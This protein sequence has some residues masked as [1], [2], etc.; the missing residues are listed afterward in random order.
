[1]EP[2]RKAAA[3][4]PPKQKPLE[5]VSKRRDEILQVAAELFAA[6]GYEETTIRE[7]GDAAGILSGSLYHHFQTK[8][9]MLHE[10]L[11]GFIAMIPEYQ[12]IVDQGRPPK[13]TMCAMIDLALRTSVSNPHTV[14]ITVQERKFLARNPTFAYVEKAWKQMSKVWYGVLEQGVADGVV[15][16]DLDLHLMLRMINDLVAAAVDWY[17]PGGRYSIGKIIDTQIALIF[18]GIGR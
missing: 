14:R 17:R 16:K 1:V 15:R 2:K 5:K 11:K 18:D 13:E 10:L 9:E 6:K 4:T 3:T 8:E 7:I 12:A